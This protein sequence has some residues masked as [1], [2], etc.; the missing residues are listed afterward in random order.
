MEEKQ[1]IKRRV[2]KV[3]PPE[4]H[5]YLAAKRQRIDLAL[6]EFETERRNGTLPTSRL[7]QRIL[8]AL[9]P[10]E[11]M[12]QGYREIWGAGSGTDYDLAVVAPFVI[13]AEEAASVGTGVRSS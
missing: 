12:P 5:A 6:R 9:P 3:L 2:A 8:A 7:G 4:E 10:L 1:L 11:G 13:A